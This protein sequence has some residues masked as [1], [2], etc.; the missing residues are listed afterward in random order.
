MLLIFDCDLAEKRKQ[1]FSSM[2]FI[3]LGHTNIKLIST[4][5]TIYLVCNKCIVIS[6][7]LGII[8]VF[9]DN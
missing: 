1:K 3:T 6:L 2:R 5:Y 9:N 8:K 4:H 7:N